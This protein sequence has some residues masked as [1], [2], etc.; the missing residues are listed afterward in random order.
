MKLK[1]H[2]AIAVVLLSQKERKA[3]I[4]EIANEI[5]KRHLY[6]QKDGSPVPWKQIM[7]RTKLSSGKYH[8]LFSYFQGDF[9]QLKNL[10][11]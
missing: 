2:E 1:L 7:M 5:N 6:A 11:A 4:V 3:H 9:V 10:E 8:H